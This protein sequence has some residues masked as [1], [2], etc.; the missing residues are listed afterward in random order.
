MPIY[1]NW[2]TGAITGDVTEAT[3][4]GWI[5]LNSAQ[6]GVGRSISMAT[7]SVADQSPSL[8]SFSEIVVTKSNDETS[9]KLLQEAYQGKGVPCTIDFVRTTGGGSTVVYLELVLENARISGHSSSSGGDAP[10]ESMTISYT[11]IQYMFTPESADGTMG[12]QA[13]VK[14]DLA[15]TTMS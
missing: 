15:T 7:G 4:T 2:N 12:T 14:Y 13:G 1:M 9:Y 5:E 8:P 10:S 3:H 6:W 11:A